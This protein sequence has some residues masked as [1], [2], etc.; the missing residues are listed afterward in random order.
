MEDYDV[1]QFIGFFV[2]ETN[3]IIENVIQDVLAMETIVDTGGELNDVD[4]LINRIFRAFHTIKG[5]S[6]AL[7]F[8]KLQKFA[9]I[10][11]NL[12]SEVREGNLQLNKEITDILLEVIDAI[13]LF[14]EGIEEDENDIINVEGIKKRIELLLDKPEKTAIISEVPSLKKKKEALSILIVEDDFISRE[15]LANSLSSYGACHIA[16]NGQ[17]SIEAFSRGLE[18]TGESPFDL[19]C[20]DIMMSKMNGIEAV[21]EIRNLEQ[22][23]GISIN[24]EAKIIMVTALEENEGIIKMLYQSGANAYLTKPASHDRIERELTKLELI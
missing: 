5:N 15:V 3:E 13:K 4:E 6:A 2:D 14:I 19:I 17:E 10:V 7:G 11:E 8:P 20:M 24:K 9:H 16:A 1:G 21:K 22:E 23:A 18:K 12:F